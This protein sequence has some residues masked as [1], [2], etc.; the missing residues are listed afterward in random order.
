MRVRITPERSL[1][2]QRI[3]ASFKSGTMHPLKVFKRLLILT[4]AAATVIPLSLLHTRLI[5]FW[6]KARIPPLAWRLGQLL[7]RVDHQCIKAVVPWMSSRLIQIIGRKEESSHKWCFQ[8]RLGRP[9]GGQSGVRLLVSPRATP[10]YQL[11]RD[12]GG[13]LDPEN[14]PTSLKGA[15]RFGPVGQ[16]DG[17]GLH[18]S[19]KRSEVM[20]SLQ[21]GSSP[22]LLGTEETHLVKGGSCGR[23]NLGT[24]MLSRG[25]VTPGKWMQHPVRE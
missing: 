11:P 13:F 4:A 24:D 25:K 21:D 12:A 2:I 15:P 5:Q 3:A 17:G 18:Q 14:L 1:T 8:L 19:P 23:L 20:L 9:V 6:L 7:V 22:P 10:A 16:H